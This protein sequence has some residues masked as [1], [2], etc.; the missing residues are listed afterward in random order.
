MSEISLITIKIDSQ[1]IVDKKQFDADN[2]FAPN[3]FVQV[4]QYGHAYL[5]ASAQVNI[6]A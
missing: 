3:D 2:A 6:F 5:L 1:T 4:D